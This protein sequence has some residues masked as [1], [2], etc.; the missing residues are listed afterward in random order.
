MLQAL[1]NSLLY[2]DPEEVIEKARNQGVD[3]QTVEDF[4]NKSSSYHLIEEVMENYRESHARW[5][6]MGGLTAG[7]G[8]FTT[9]ITFAGIDTVSLSIQLYHLSERFAILNGFDADNPLHKDK[10]LDIYFGALGIN[11]IA[12]AALKHQLLKAGALTKAGKTSGNFVLNIVVR[13]A[14]LMG[15]NLSSKKA[16]QLIPLIGGLAGASFNYSFARE[17]SKILKRAYKQAYF[18]TWH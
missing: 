14:K 1:Q 12:Q 5:S 18:D 13:I 9:S 2:I 7:I 8:G 4:R 16:G 11:A 3:V 6:A 10:I 15:N 17:S